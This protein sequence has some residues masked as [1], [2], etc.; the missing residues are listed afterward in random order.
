[1][2][3]SPL[4]DTVSLLHD[5]RDVTEG[6]CI[7]AYGKYQESIAQGQSVEFLAEEIKVHGPCNMQVKL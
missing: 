5:F 4:Y 2:I 3:L 6:S 7:T 1:M